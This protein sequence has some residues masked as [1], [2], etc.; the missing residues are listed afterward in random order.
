M[1]RI[2]RI[3]IFKFIDHWVGGPVCI[4]LVLLYRLTHPFYKTHLHIPEKE[5]AEKI[6]VPREVLVDFRVEKL[7]PEIDWMRSRSN[8]I[9]A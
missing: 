6:G 1:P 8:A 4:F 9:L 7:A 3:T 5:L 2:E